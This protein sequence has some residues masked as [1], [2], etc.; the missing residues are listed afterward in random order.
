ME[1]NALRL[2]AALAYYSIFSI[3]PLLI[4]ALSIA[5]L[6]L[7]PDAVRGQLGPQLER[8]IGAQAAEAVQSI[9]KGASK[10][11]QG[12]VGATVGFLTLMLARQ[13]FLL[14]SRMR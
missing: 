1:D 12:W 8:Y 9:V 4:I 13:E 14:S 10:P 7:G 2:S 6:V 11:S 5:G 3:A